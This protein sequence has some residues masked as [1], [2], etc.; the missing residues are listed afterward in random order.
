M[1]KERGTATTTQ[2]VKEINFQH[3]CPNCGREFPTAHGMKIHMARWCTGDTEERSRKGTL[4]DMKIKRVKYSTAVKARD[5]VVLN[6]IPVE[7]V[8]YFEY[9]GSTFNAG[10]GSE[11][12]IKKRMNL[13][14]AKFARLHHIWGDARL[15]RDLRI[16]LNTVRVVSTLLY[17]CESWHLNT[18]ALKNLRGFHSRCLARIYKCEP[19]EVLQQPLGPDI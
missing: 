12:N 17:G 8:A 7:N 4:A 5:S 3:P 18:A 16:R 19:A 13:V 2:D 1:I 14:M 10:G 15:S 6:R 9:L 11:E